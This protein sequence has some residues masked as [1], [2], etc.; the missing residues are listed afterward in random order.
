MPGRD[1]LVVDVARPAV[2]VEPMR[3]TQCAMNAISSARE[4]HELGWL[5]CLDGLAA[6]LA[7]TVQ[8]APGPR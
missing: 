8:A 3:W 1:E 4:G 6:F 7:I 5:S 2:A